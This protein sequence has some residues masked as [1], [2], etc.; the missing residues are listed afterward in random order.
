MARRSYARKNMAYRVLPGGTIEADTIE[1]L[2]ALQAIQAGSKKGKSKPKSS[3]DREYSVN[4][5]GKVSYMR[6]KMISLSVGGMSNFCPSRASDRETAADAL[7]RMGL[8]D[9]RAAAVLSAMEKAG[10]YGPNLKDPAKAAKAAEIL[11]SVGGISCSLKNP[12]RGRNFGRMNPFF[13]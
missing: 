6:G 1:E 7:T 3:E 13:F 4:E 5:G 11:S 2:R 8:T 12:R 10:V 9:D